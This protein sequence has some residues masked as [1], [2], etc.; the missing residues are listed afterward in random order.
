MAWVRVIVVVIAVL[1]MGVPLIR[2]CAPDE[3]Q[4]SATATTYG[5]G[6]GHSIDT[7]SMRQ[8]MARIVRDRGYWCETP[9]HALPASMLGL[10]SN[11]WEIDLTCDDGSRVARYRVVV[12]PDTRDATVRRL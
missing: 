8:E 1:V 7:P 11:R 6:S 10:D 12:D 3:P 9:V 5:Q 2:S 4:P